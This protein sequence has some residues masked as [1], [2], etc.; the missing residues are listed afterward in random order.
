MMPSPRVSGGIC[1]SSSCT[2]VTGMS[3]SRVHQ[4]PSVADTPGTACSFA[5]A[6]SRTLSVSAGVSRRNR[7]TGSQT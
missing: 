4:E 6:G 2:L 5:S 1:Y 7:W 3:P